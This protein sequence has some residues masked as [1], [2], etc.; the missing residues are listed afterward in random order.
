MEAA[1]GRGGERCL[2][3]LFTQLHFNFLFNLVPINFA[4]LISQ[5]QSRQRRG[6]RFSGAVALSEHEIGANIKIH[7][8]WLKH[9]PAAARVLSDISS[10]NSGEK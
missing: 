1:K 8:V 5:K 6:C 10:I 7:L 2:K 9:A 3:R 4:E